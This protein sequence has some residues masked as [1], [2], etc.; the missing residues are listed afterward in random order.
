[1]CWAFGANRGSFSHTSDFLKDVYNTC[2]TLSTSVEN[3]GRVLLSVKGHLSSKERR[4]ME[5]CLKEAKIVRKGGC[6][7]FS[8]SGRLLNTEKRRKERP[9]QDKIRPSLPA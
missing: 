2:E 3:T 6:P 8:P 1:M 5:T 4:D 7:V 9:L